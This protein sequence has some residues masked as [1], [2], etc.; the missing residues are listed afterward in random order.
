MGVVLDMIKEEKIA[1]R[2]VLLAGE[3]GTGNIMLSRIS[4]TYAYFLS[5]LVMDS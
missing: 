3:P 4:T 1:G 5:L 2:S